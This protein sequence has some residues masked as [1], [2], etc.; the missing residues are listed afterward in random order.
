[1]TSIIN[2]EVEL[3]L[4]ERFNI[5]AIRISIAWSRIFPNGFGKVNAKSVQFIINYLKNVKKEKLLL[6]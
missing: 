4:C 3:E 2:I 1:M 6:L 5:K